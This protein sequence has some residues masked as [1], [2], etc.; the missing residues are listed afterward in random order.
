MDLRG[1]RWF[2]PQPGLGQSDRIIR[3]MAPPS[4][5]V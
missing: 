2:D 3:E 1:A 4:P 5:K